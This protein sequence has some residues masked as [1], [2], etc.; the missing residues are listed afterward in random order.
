[1]KTVKY[2]FWGIILIY[3]QFLIAN[4]FQLM[5]I[6]PNLFTPF[7]IYINL[8]LNYSSSLPISFFMGISFDLMYPELLGLHSI[9]YVLLSFI[10]IVFHHNINKEKFT[11]VLLSILLLTTIHYGLFFLYY[12]IAG[13]LHLI[14]PMVFIFALLYNTLISLIVIYLFFVIDS[15]KLQL[16]V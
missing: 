15:I 3:V 6:I 16:D 2:F 8:K 13:Y 5:G 1:M 7:I 9:S 10:I 14:K 4:K 11:I 12:L